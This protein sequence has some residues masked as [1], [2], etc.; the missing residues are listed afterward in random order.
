MFTGMALGDPVNGV[1]DEANALYAKYLTE[2]DPYKVAEAQDRITILYS[3]ANS[4]EVIHWLSGIL[5]VGMT[6][7]GSYLLLDES[8][9]N[10]NYLNVK[11]KPFFE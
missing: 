4:I 10:K 9:D 5:G 3:R 7:T 2:T 1:L 8:E 11:L 6:I